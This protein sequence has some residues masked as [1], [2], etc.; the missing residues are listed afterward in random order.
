MC[1]ELLDECEARRRF[2]VYGNGGFAACE[3]VAGGVGGAGC[4]AVEAEDGGAVVGEE[5]A[6][7]GT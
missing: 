3:L 1:Y 5:E 7:E 6:C 4:C 2:E